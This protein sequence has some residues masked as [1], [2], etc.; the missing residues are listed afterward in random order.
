MK[1]I[2]AM[3]LINTKTRDAWAYIIAAGDL[4]ITMASFGFRV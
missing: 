1:R 3:H 4:E 2:K